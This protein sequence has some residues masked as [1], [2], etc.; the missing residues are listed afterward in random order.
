MR[1]GQEK[2]HQSCAVQ[3]FSLHAPISKLC[4]CTATLPAITVGEGVG[5]GG[6]GYNYISALFTRD[7]IS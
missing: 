4:S 7:H 6:G 2:G 5:G 1:E 3:T